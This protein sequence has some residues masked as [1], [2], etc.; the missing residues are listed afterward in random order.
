MA[1][2]GRLSP[3]GDEDGYAE[4]TG[5]QASAIRGLERWFDPAAVGRR[6]LAFTVAFGL[7]L[8]L[9]GGRLDVGGSRQLVL[10]CVLVAAVQVAAAVLPW[11][12]WPLAWQTLLP[13]AQMGALVELELGTG[14]SRSYYTVLL[15]LPVVSLALQPRVLGLVLSVVGA[16]AVVLVPA[17]RG[18]EQVGLASG[19]QAVI[20]SVTA[21]LGAIGIW[22]ITQKLR[23]RTADVLR[24]QRRQAQVLRSVQE[25]HDALRGLIDAAVGQA[26]V[27]TDAGGRVEIFNRGAEA[28]LGHT[29]EHAVGMPV[30]VLFDTVT[31]RAHLRAQGVD[32]SPQ[33]R[34]AAVVGSA[35][36]GQTEHREWTFVRADGE[37]VPVE[38]SVDR[39]PHDEGRA[40]GYLV[41]ATDVSE[42]Q[43]A[44]RLQDEFVGLVSHELRTPLASVLGYVD[45]LRAD[46]PTAEQDRYL[47]VIERNGQR[48]LRLVNDLLLSAQVAAGKFVLTTGPLDAAEVVRSSV[49]NVEP[50]AERAGVTVVTQVEGP[51]PLVSDDERLGQ[52]VENL[53]SNGVK[54][55]PRGGE[56]TVTLEPTTV[57]GRG[58]G[59]HLVVAD[60]G[61]GIASDELDRITERFYRATAARTTRVRGIG[62]GLPIVQSIVDA[63]G[64]TMHIHSVLGSGTTITVDLPDAP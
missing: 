16:A 20:V 45:L 4:V 25:G 38:V 44:E 53:V 63:H 31:L 36:S 56:V 32:D 59:V 9:L 46:T 61:R 21:L 43:E 22:A 23:L 8:V 18:P 55:T 28:L 26:I 37:L 54:F 52:L 58:R 48:L 12:R 50:V 33:A 42:R 47:T 40:A 49:A 29:A 30:T 6:Q 14:A 7:T 19:V 27:T 2:R 15:F 1:Q 34:L 35:A 11:T 51:A 62:L 17:A 5:W 57:P 39:L 64:G 60:T 41:I 24:L 3:G 10:S 13:V